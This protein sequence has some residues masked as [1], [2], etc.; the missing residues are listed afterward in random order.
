MVACSPS[1]N[2]SR[3]SSPASTNRNGPLCT[4]IEMRSTTR[5]RPVTTG[6]AG[7]QRRTH[8]ERRAARP[9]GVTL[10]FEEQEQRVA[11]ELDEVATFVTCHAE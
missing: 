3:W 9:L 1:T 2:S 11:T 4:P 8:P 5:P 6:P 10:A 7:L